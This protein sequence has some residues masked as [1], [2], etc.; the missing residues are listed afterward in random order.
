MGFQVFTIVNMEHAAKNANFNQ[1]AEEGMRV[2]TPN[3]VDR[4]LAALKHFTAGSKQNHR[5]GT[6]AT[7][8]TPAK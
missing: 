5:N 4:A 2:S 3:I 6:L 1:A 8:A 7:G